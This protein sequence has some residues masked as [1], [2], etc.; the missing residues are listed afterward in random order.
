MAS[1]FALFKQLFYR[2]QMFSYEQTEIARYYCDY[3][4][5]MAH[6]DTVLPGW[7]HRVI[8]EDLVEDTEGEVRRLL[9]FC[10][11]PF[12]AACLDFWTSARAVPTHSSEQVRQ[13]IFR[14]G[15]ERWRHYEP[16][17]GPI[18]QGVQTV[19]PFWRHAARR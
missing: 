8:Y 17:L 9:A 18:H 5:L 16:W 7:I 14:S 13:P 10:G 19:M 1:C 11:L 4:H 12:N 15:L 6:F 3:A 2:G